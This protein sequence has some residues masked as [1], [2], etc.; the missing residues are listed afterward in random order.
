VVRDVDSVLEEGEPSGGG[1]EDA[2]L[3]VCEPLLELVP[4]NAARKRF[5]ERDFTHLRAQ[6]GESQRVFEANHQQ[7]SVIVRAETSSTACAAAH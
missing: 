6:K 3:A 2:P 5:H 4:K 1:V 7:Q